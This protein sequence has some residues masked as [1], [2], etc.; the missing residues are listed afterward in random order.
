MKYHSAIKRN[1]VIPQKFRYRVTTWLSNPTSEH[2]RNERR[3]NESRDSH[4]HL[5]MVTAALFQTAPK[6]KQPRSLLKDKQTKCGIYMYTG[7]LFSL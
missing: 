1:E 3:R 6:W 2:I 4:R 7:I 5:H